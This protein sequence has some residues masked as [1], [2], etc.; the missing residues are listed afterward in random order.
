SGR[1][2][3]DSHRHD[4]LTLSEVLEK[5]SNIGTAQIALTLPPQTMHASLRESG[6]GQAVG[7]PISAATAGRLRPWQSWVAIDQATISYGHGIAVSL[8]Q[9]ARAYTVFAGD[10]RLLPLSLEPQASLPSGERVFSEQTALTIRGACSS[11]RRARRALPPRPRSMAL[12]W[13]ERRERPTSPSAAATPAIATSPHS[14][15]L[16]RPISRAW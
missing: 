7:L 4:R 11:A 1:T 2:I 15:D 6:F 9:L 16:S 10:G 12:R 14:L 8:V 5:S 3:R 13:Q